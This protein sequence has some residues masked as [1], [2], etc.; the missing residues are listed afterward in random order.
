MFNREE[1]KLADYKKKLNDIPIPTE[2]LDEQIHLGLQRAKS[3]KRL[4]KSRKRRMISLVAAA[5]L[6]LGFFTTIRVSPT[7]A[8]YI[9]IVPG[10]EKLVE[11]IRDDKGRMLAVENEYYQEIGVSDEDNGL[12]ITIDG[13]IADEQGMVLFYTLE[14]DEKQRELFVDRPQLTSQDGT[15][16]DWGTISSGGPHYS[17]KGE[18]SFNGT[19]EYFFQSPYEAR[20]FELSV[21]VNGEGDEWNFSLPFS[22]E[23]ELAK[24]KVYN[25]NKAVEIEGQT[26]EILE[27]VVHPLRVAVQ[28]RMDE[29]NT[30]K[31]LDFQDLRLVDEN[32]E[33]WTK[34]A[35]GTTASHISDHEKI[36]Y[37]QSNYFKEPEELY[38]VFN[39]IQAVD[40]DEAYVVVDPKT[41]EILKQPK[42]DHL[43]NF[44]VRGS[45]L[46]FD[47]HAK[48][49][50]NYFLFNRISDE[51]GN[52]LESSSFVS[53]PNQDG[54]E[55]VG[56]IIPNLE[57]V[58]G[59]ISLELSFYP[60][61][62]E[63][64][65]RVKVK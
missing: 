39:K 6:I 56:V 12:K 15:K 27:A 22:I 19:V 14:S 4:Q 47:F 65:A 2:L 3:E 25:I 1:E 35:N 16:L 18:T 54:I 5:V 33:S 44:K 42:G 60:S 24:K 46:V 26:I 31:L 64:D 29:Q 57:N 53:G 63:G 21:Q 32:A 7:F 59:P 8:H 28:I 62:L 9:T 43:R 23:E 10:M 34:I 50:F 45:D 48:E 51:G 52:E 11:L 40:K 61:W 20:D 58:H 41:E 37:L 49:E 17:E 13:A 55:E 30:K 38:L 36:I